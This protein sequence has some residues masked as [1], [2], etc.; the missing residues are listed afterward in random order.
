MK[1]L[2]LSSWYPSQLYP[3]DGDFIQRHAAAASLFN[4][5]EV[6]YVVKDPDGKVT[7]DVKEV[8]VKNGGLTERIIY[9]KPVKTAVGLLNRFLS[10]LRYKKEYKKAVER[11]IST[12]GKPAFV[13]VH[14]AMKAGLIALWL[15]KKHQIP[16]IISEQWVGYFDGASPSIYE[17]NCIYRHYWKQI[18]V[19]AFAGTFVS[20]VLKNQLIKLYQVQNAQVIPN[21]VNTDI[22]K[23]VDHLSQSPIRFIHIS[24]MTYQKNLEAILEALA[25]LKG[26][27]AFEMDIYG[28]PNDN[29]RDL[30][31][32]LDLQE[33]VF[34]KGEVPHSELTKALQRSDALILYSR[35]ETF[36]CVLIEAN[37]CGVPVI[38]SDIPVFHEIVKEGLNGMFV[39]GEDPET[40]AEKLK[41]FAEQKGSFDKNAIAANAATKYNYKEIGQQFDKFYQEIAAKLQ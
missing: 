40:L 1:I 25:I 38:V 35:F 8:V 5:I 41:Q 21:V 22:F 24:I 20:T 33:H 17:F 19:E 30:I 13:H 4:E 34:I 28:P 14:I 18:F 16:Y 39:K 31:R 6:I 26:S 29:I 15:K 12:N 37:A 2:W 9:Y 3:Y 36:G 32:E 7:N 11:Y 10:T 27:T 23:P